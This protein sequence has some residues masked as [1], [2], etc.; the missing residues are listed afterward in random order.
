MAERKWFR[1]AL[2]ITGALA[3]GHGTIE[4]FRVP[5]G[6]VKAQH[7]AEKKHPD[8]KEAFTFE[9]DQRVKELEDSIRAGKK[10]RSE[11]LPLALIEQKYFHAERNAY[12][13][14][15]TKNDPSNAYATQLGAEILGGGSGIFFSL[16]R[17]KR[18]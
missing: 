1:T 15:A 9:V 13:K 7:E 6:I 14:I 2:F 10:V 17:R 5:E 16:F 3:L 8:G 18:F 11:E 12:L 4:G